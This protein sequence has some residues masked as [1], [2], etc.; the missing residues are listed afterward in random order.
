MSGILTAG[1][2]LEAQL[3]AAAASSLFASARLSEF[4]MAAISK[5]CFS[6]G[7]D[8]AFIPPRKNNKGE[9]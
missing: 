2:R 6:A 5:L 9:Q 8:G 7:C 1:Q 3:P 4:Q